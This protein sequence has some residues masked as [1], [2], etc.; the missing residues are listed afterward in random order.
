MAS[1]SL[2]T[3]S[4]GLIFTKKAKKVYRSSRGD[5]SACCGSAVN[6]EPFAA[7]VER[8]MKGKF[9]PAE[10]DMGAIV[11]SDGKV[12]SFESGILRLCDYPHYAIGSASEIALGAMAMGANAVR[13][14]EICIENNCY[15]GGEIQ[16][17]YA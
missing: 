4:Y 9:V 14:V 1:D 11:V 16:I 12:F 17:A 2:E 10:D 15:C 6:A 7:W 5:L 13:A 3:G 8:G